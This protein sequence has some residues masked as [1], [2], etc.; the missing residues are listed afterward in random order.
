MRRI[1][2]TITTATAAIVAATALG[3]SAAVAAPVGSTGAGSPTRAG[4]NPCPFKP[5]MEMPRGTYRNL[6]CKGLDLHGLHF[7]YQSF[8]A[9]VDFTGANLDGANF[10]DVWLKPG[11][12][13]MARTSLRNAVLPAPHAD[14]Q[15]VS[16]FSDA[17]LT[18]SRF[19]RS[20]N[21]DARNTRFIRAKM[22]G[23]QFWQ[24]SG[25]LD[26]RG[27]DF[28]GA[29][30]TNARFDRVD[31]QGAILYGA[32]L[33]GATLV[34]SSFN[35]ANFTRATMNKVDLRSS[36]FIGSQVT[37]VDMSQGPTTV[38]RV[39][40][41]FG[42]TNWKGANARGAN[43]ASLEVHDDWI[44]DV[45]TCHTTMPDGRQSDAWC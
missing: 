42:Y 29:D 9:D 21:I 3:A 32:N 19:D 27:S 18:G 41:F 25:G 10:T 36:D 44:K 17:D 4:W 2:R 12:M 23:F 15:V 1:I 34:V 16:D 14:D 39:N 8:M 33:T 6:D 22:A 43:L 26:L 5:G 13:E 30:L 38:G 37:Q 24:D 35:N 40:V 11:L 28:S 7:Q 20:A 45:Q 31:A